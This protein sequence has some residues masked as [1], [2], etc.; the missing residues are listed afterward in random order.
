MENDQ[1]INREKVIVEFDRRAK[2]HRD[3]N[4]VLDAG[5]KP[6]IRHQNILR[7]HLTYHYL[8]KRLI[9]SKK[10]VILD[11]GCGMGRLTYLINPKVKEIFGVDQSPAMIETAIQLPPTI[12]A[13]VFKQLTNNAIPFPDCSFNKVFT[14]WVFQHVNDHEFKKL[15]VEIIRVLKPGGI[16]VLLEQVKENR[17]ILSDIHIHR[18]VN[19]YVRTI[20]KAGFLLEKCNPIMRVTSYAMSIWNKYMSL[21]RLILPFLACIETLTIKYK[22]ENVNYFTWSFVFKKDISL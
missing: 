14:V 7:H 21:N 16:L 8:L 5:D 11:F 18:T 13:D 4:A 6:D 9:P 12:S 20:T 2:L 10:D 22:V 15:A 17:E 19:E 3:L 1:L